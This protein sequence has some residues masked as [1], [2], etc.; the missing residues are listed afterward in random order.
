MKISRAEPEL[1]FNSQSATLRWPDR[2]ICRPKRDRQDFNLRMFE[3]DFGNI[4]R[5]GS[6]TEYEQFSLRTSHNELAQELLFASETRYSRRAHNRR[7]IDGLIS[8]FLEEV[9]Q[10][11]I[12]GSRAFYYLVEGVDESNSRIDFLRSDRIFHFFGEYFQFLPQR[13]NN[14]WEA[15]ETELSREMRILD[16]SKLFC[17]RLPN[18]IK[19]MIS[20]QNKV[21]RMIDANQNSSANFLPE[22]T[23]E[24]PNPNN[25]FDFQVWHETQDIS[26]YRA[27]RETGWNARKWDSSKR[28]DFFDCHRAIRFRRNQ[29]TL[30]DALLVQMSKEFTR[31]GKRFEPSFSLEIIPTEFL[32]SVGRL[33]ELE[34]GLFSETVSFTEVIDYCYT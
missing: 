17:F 29:L 1:G 8:G 3:Q 7:E 28:S 31:V 2:F 32:P 16:Q 26:M 12:G 23:L 20:T 21:L 14:D 9:A 34:L 30:R 27:T 25:N 11:L 4:F 10:S 24:N 18:H 15:E 33:N 5:R 13:Q 6:L 22:I 19:K